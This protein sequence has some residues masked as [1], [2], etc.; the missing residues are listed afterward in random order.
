MTVPST[1]MLSKGYLDKNVYRPYQETHM[2]GGPSLGKEEKGKNV[3]Q[4][5]GPPTSKLPTFDGTKNWNTFV[6][7]FERLT[8]HYGWDEEE[9]LNRLGESFLDDALDYI[10]SVSEYMHGD[11]LHLKDK[12]TSA[13]GQS[14]GN[15][16][17][18]GK[19]CPNQFRP[20]EITYQINGH[21]MYEGGKKQNV[22]KKEM[23]Q[24]I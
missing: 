20:S 5:Y 15:D 7:Q 9:K 23:C 3:P 10:S 21:M 1:S 13:F 12:M 24:F 11:F 4:N 18:Y 6:F 2:P 22:R 8:K 19:D 16:G 17:H 14:C